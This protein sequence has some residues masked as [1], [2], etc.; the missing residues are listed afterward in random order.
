MQIGGNWYDAV[1]KPGDAN[2]CYTVRGGAGSGNGVKVSTDDGLSWAMSGTGQP[3]VGSMGK[4]KLAVSADT[5]R[6]KPWRS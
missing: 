4:T 3:L 2:R 5:F 6:N 1:W